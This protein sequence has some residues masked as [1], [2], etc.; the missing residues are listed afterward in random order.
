MDPCR[1]RQ[2]VLHQRPV[3]PGVSADEFRHRP[4]QCSGRIR[5]PLLASIRHDPGRLPAR[6]RGVRCTVRPGS[7]AIP[8]AYSRALACPVYCPAAVRVS[9]TAGSHRPSKPRITGAD[10]DAACSSTTTHEPPERSADYWDTTATGRRISGRAAAI[11]ARTRPNVQTIVAPVGRS[12][13]TEK[14]M[15]SIETTLPMTHAIA[16]LGP[17]RPENSM[18]PTEGTM[19]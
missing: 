13:R 3:P 16:S 10:H 18:P 4:A 15:P 5:V 19:R 7:H 17:T 2:S 14:Y 9:S 8:E 11:R 12:N 1:P 6:D